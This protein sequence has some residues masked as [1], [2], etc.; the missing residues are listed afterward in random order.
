MVT[1]HQIFRT[2]VHSIKQGGPEVK[3][4]KAHQ[5]EENGHAR[6]R[7]QWKHRATRKQKIE[8]PQEDIISQ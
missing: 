4:I 5:N 8:W 7:K 1:A 3:P 6:T 2:E